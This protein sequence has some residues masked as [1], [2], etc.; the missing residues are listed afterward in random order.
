MGTGGAEEKDK[1]QTWSRDTRVARETGEFH[2]SQ[3]LDRGVKSVPLGKFADG[4]V[5]IRAETR[6]PQRP[7]QFE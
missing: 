4:R 7:Q 6:L 2:T 5:E 3:C 1:E